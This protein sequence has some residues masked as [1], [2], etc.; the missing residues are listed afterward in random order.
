MKSR[1][2]DS[3]EAFERLL[4]SVNR[5]DQRTLPRY[6]FHK[7]IVDNS[8]KLTAPEIDYFFDVLTGFKNLSSTALNQRQWS[9]KIADEKGS[10]LQV[11]RQIAQK[12]GLNRDRILKAVDLRLWDPALDFDSFLSLIRRLDASLS[13]QLAKEAFT[14]LQNRNQK[15]EIETLLANICGS[16]S[17]TID[18]K[19][20]MFKTLYIEIYQKHK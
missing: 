5:I 19:V 11:L 3:D 8:V 15:V 12:Y 2:Y 13:E 16:E 10:P 18:F 20:S 17:E 1:N 9:T 6:E 4:R 14:R 7:A